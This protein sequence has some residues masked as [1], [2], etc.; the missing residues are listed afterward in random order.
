M[1]AVGVIIAVVWY[2]N[3]KTQESRMA[4]S[5]DEIRIVSPKPGWAVGTYEDVT[6]V[7]PRPGLKCY[8]VVEPLANNSQDE[9]YLEKQSTVSSSQCTIHAQFGETFTPSGTKFRI[10]AFLTKSDLQPGPFQWG[11]RRRRAIPFDHCDQK[12]I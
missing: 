8:L 9:K 5:K 1:L 11:A 4:S 6:V 2:I 10:H 3:S 7:G 12:M